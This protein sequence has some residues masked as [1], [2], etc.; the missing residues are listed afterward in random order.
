MR[1][2]GWAGDDWRSLSQRDKT[3]IIAYEIRRSEDRAEKIQA[4][5]KAMRDSEGKNLTTDIILLRMWQ[6]I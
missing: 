6:T 1:A 3:D 2:R 5:Q 4:V